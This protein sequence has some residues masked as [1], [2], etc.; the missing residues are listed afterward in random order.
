[1]TVGIDGGGNDDLL[2]VAVVGREQ[3]TRRWLVWARA[4]ANINAL[5]RRLSE[6]AAMV[7]FAHDGDLVVVDAFGPIPPEHHPQPPRRA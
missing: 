3:D 1:M 6:A 2:A 5:R 7:D 4:F